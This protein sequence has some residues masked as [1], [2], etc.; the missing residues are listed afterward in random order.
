MLILRTSNLA[1]NWPH[2]P[3]SLPSTQ[4][5]WPSQNKSRLKQVPSPQ[6]RSPRGHMGSTVLSIGFGACSSSIIALISVIRSLTWSNW[7]FTLPFGSNLLKLINWEEVI[8]CSTLRYSS[9]LISKTGY[10]NCSNQ[11]TILFDWFTIPILLHKF[12]PIN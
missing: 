11:F 3:S 6:A 10:F 4:S 2:H 9:N 7:L 12:N 5:V 8:S 1:W